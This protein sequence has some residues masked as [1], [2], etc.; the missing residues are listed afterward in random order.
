MKLSVKLESTPEFLIT[1]DEA[2]GILGPLP[3]PDDCLQSP[4]ALHWLRRRLKP[5]TLISGP[6]LY[7][8]RDVYN[9]ANQ[10][11][12]RTVR[13]TRQ[14]KPPVSH[15]LPAGLAGLTSRPLRK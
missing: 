6:L 13:K 12:R 1:E 9:L 7:R 8:G 3:A 14:A 5:F 10:L 4:T 11:I 15:R 2:I